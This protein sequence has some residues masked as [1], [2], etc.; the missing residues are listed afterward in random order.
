MKI[1]NILIIYIY[2]YMECNYCKEHLKIPKKYF[3]NIFNHIKTKKNKKILY[4]FILLN[5]YFKNLK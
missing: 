1:K 4:Y 3:N 2:I 5:I